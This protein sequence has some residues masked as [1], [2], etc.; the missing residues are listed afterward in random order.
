MLDILGGDDFVM[1]GIS[2]TVGIFFKEEF[3]PL[4]QTSGRENFQPMAKILE[5]LLKK[6]LADE[7]YLLIVELLKALCASK[8]EGG[9][10]HC[11]KLRVVGSAVADGAQ[12]AA[13]IAPAQAATAPPAAPTPAHPLAVGVHVVLSA[14]KA[15]TKK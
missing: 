13:A 3:I 2:Q 15:A 7:K 1:E 8:T 9:D 5:P 11:G 6:V 4:G 10:A 14:K 12:E